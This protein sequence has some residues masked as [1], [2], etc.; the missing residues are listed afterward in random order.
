M[1]NSIRA[2]ISVLLP[3]LFF[4]L[5]LSIPA[6][7]FFEISTDEGIN[8]MKAELLRQGYPLYAETWSDQPPLF[9]HLLAGAFNLVGTRVETLRLVVAFLSSLLLFGAFHF[10]RLASGVK[11][12][13]IGLILIVSLPTYL[14]LSVSIMVGL[15]SIVLAVL[16][17]TSLGIWHRDRRPFLLVLSA[18]FL[19]LAT[20][21]KLITGILVPILFAGLLITG[22]TSAES[23]TNRWRN[24]VPAAAW[25]GVFTL[26]FVVIAVTLVGV[27]N[28]PQL[29]TNHLGAARTQ[30]F[31]S[32]GEFRLAAHIGPSYPY[33]FLGL[34]AGIDALIRRKWLLMYPFA[35]M[36][37]A[38]LTMRFY[39]PVWYHHVILI[40]IPAAIL[41]A[42]PV[43][44]ALDWI[45]RFVRHI[46]SRWRLSDSLHLAAI[47]GLGLFLLTWRTPD[48]VQYLPFTTTAGELPPIS[49]QS[50]DMLDCIAGYRAETAWFL[51]DRPMYAFRN[52]LL[53]P[54]EFAVMSFKRVQT[55]EI[56]ET[57]LVAGVEAYR[58]ELILLS[59][60]S[61]PDFET[62]LADDY[63][64]LDLNDAGERLYIHRTLLNLAVNSGCD[65]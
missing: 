14:I 37:S 6:R 62:G 32:E 10:I 4:L 1:S 43:A 53:V 9:T 51:T 13:V 49:A 22:F 44:A 12:A 54:P 7:G 30:T 17:M 3:A 11:E 40:T 36:L 15:P 46:A 58:P 45:P 23:R 56:T 29:I 39:T 52:D 50:G 24:L 8:L 55:G 31:V 57:D 59:R 33:L 26:V 27:E 25:G 28:L 63:T 16:S 42:E 61:F 5:A 2:A 21:I 47:A 38:Y 20:M 18:V 35:W 34:I 41:A 48:P 60:F 65:P 19:S 64:L